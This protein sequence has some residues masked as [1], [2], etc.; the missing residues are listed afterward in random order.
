MSNR[1]FWQ[2]NIVNWKHQVD[3]NH[4]SPYA[5]RTIILVSTWLF[6]LYIIWHYWS[7][8]LSNI[9][10]LLART[11]HQSVGVVKDILRMSHRHSQLLIQT[12]RPIHWIF[13]SFGLGRNSSKNYAGFLG[14]NKVCTCYSM[15]RSQRSNR[16]C[17]LRTLFVYFFA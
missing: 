12:H 16:D 10:L 6:F 17:L 5:F 1:F 11:S 7:N 8:V 15:N 2:Y 13:S 3:Y 9:Q 14:K 4:S